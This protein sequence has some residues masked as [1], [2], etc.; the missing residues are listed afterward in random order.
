MGFIAY[1][2]KIFSPVTVLA[3]IV[4]VPLA[5][6]I[7]LCGFS[8]IIMGLIYPPLAHLFAHTNELLV[9]LL[10]NIN[11]FLIKIPYAYFYLHKK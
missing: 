8:L 5:A 4:I 3:N 1:H 11:G 7:T 6:L 9:M 10:L 2:F